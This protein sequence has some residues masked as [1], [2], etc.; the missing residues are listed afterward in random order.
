LCD[1]P[2][3][4]ARQLR[5]AGK[6]RHDPLSP[7]VFGCPRRRD[8]LFGKFGFYRTTHLVVLKRKLAERLFELPRE[9]L[10]MLDD[11]KSLAYSYYVYVHH[12]QG[13]HYTL[14]HLL[15][16]DL[17]V[18]VPYHNKDLGPAMVKSILK[19]AGL[20]VDDLLNLL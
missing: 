14:R 17:R 19:Q 18:T 20:T 11:P 15:K 5:R 3:G 4:V 12:I 8:A 7:A 2:G 1:A 13:S 16:S 9:L 10:R 6:S